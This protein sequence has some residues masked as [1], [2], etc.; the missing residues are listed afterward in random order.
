MSRFTLFRSRFRLV[1]ALLA[2]WCAIGAGSVMYAGSASAT[3]SPSRAMWVWSKAS[4]TDVVSFAQSHGVSQM[5]VAVP[6]NVANSSDLPRLRQLSA[7]ARA[8]GIRVDALG[9]DPS[10]TTNPSAAVTWERGAI[11]TRLFTGVHV[12]IEPYALS[13]W[14][15]PSTQA[16]L[17]TSYLSTL[18][19]MRS[20]AAASGMPLEADVPFWYNTIATGSTTLADGVLAR[21]DAVTVMSYRNTATGP[22][23]ITDIGSDMIA[24]GAAAG[25]PVRLAAETNPLSDCPSCTFAGTS[26][27]TLNAALAAVDAAE[28]GS[29]SYV[30]MAVEDY[31]GWRALP[32]TS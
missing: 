31:D 13:G 29:S 21:V 6:W 1:I 7:A 30:G 24:R 17:V 8:V 14:S 23:S 15:N 16:S 5:F 20:T 4:P 9:G 12:D 3:T 32:A 26:A 11:A 19:S 10:W 22:N 28:A 25:V 18:S 27:A 2:A